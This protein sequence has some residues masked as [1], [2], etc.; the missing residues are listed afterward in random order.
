M[1][2]TEISQEMYLVPSGHTVKLVPPSNLI[3]YPSIADLNKLPFC[4]YF[5]NC[6]SESQLMNDFAAEACGW[7]SASDSIGKTI[8]VVTNAKTAQHVLNEHQTILKRNKL[9]ITEH[10]VLRKDDLSFQALNIIRPWKNSNNELLGVF[11]CSIVLG[12]ESIFTIMTRVNEYGLL[13]TKVSIE[14]LLSSAVFNGH[15]FS[16]REMECLQYYIKGRTAKQIAKE[17]KLSYRTVQHYLENIKCKMG[18]SSKSE[19]IS[20]VTES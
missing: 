9:T 15:Y 18:V 4:I 6:Q 8:E 5:L 12:S 11:G 19:L 17:L 16:K 3:E 2:N 1:K 14:S 20:K 13:D 7:I 10:E